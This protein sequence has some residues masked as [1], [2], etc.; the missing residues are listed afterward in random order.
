MTTRYIDDA[1]RL[2]EKSRPAS[3]PSRNDLTFSTWRTALPI[4]RVVI[5]YLI[6]LKHLFCVFVVCESGAEP[7]SLSFCPICTGFSHIE[8]AR[9][10][11]YA[12]LFHFSF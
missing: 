1:A 9:F 7:S 5:C 11:L 8:R 6:I 12:R 2:V 4:E 10:E 3:S